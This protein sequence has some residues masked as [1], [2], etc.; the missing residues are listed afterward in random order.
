MDISGM[1]SGKTHLTQVMELVDEKG[2]IIPG[3][4]VRQDLRRGL[5]QEV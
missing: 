5:P 1:I 2:N 4:V 3:T